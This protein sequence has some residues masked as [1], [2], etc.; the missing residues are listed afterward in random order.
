MHYDVGHF[1][2]DALETH[3]TLQRGRNISLVLLEELC[4]RLLE[5]AGFVPG[6]THSLQKFKK[7]TCEDTPQASLGRS[8]FDGEA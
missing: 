4:S 2:P 6:E 3:Q 7:A 8:V 1:P 5:E